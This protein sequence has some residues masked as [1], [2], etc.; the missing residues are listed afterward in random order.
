MLYI[1]TAYRMN[2]PDAGRGKNTAINV[3]SEVTKRRSSNVCFSKP[4]ISRRSTYF[5]E[6]AN[7]IDADDYDSSISSYGSLLRDEE[8]FSKLNVNH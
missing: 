1:V 7:M 4:I 8:V 3:S 5:E 2:N 6:Q